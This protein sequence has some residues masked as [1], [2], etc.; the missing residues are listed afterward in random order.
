MLHSLRGLI[1]LF[2]AV[3]VLLYS[4]FA[5]RNYLRGVSLVVTA[6]ADGALLHSPSLAVEGIALRS[7]HLFVNGAKVFPDKDGHFSYALLLPPGYFIIDVTAE[8]R[9]QRTK[10]VRREVVYQPSVA[11]ST[12]TTT[13]H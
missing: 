9:F 10:T 7:S 12:A 4:L 11:T 5:A 6:P 8:D 2:I 1:F 3:L 13:N